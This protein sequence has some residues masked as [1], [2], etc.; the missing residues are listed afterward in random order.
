MIGYSKPNV[1]CIL[2]YR[3]EKRD[4]VN[5]ATTSH[6]PFCIRYTELYRSIDSLCRAARSVTLEVTE[7]AGVTPRQTPLL[8]EIAMLTDV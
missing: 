4:S 1:Q 8:I 5:F 3:D 6:L 2:L 7:S